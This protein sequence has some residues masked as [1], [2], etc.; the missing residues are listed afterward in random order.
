MQKDIT[1]LFND[2]LLKHHRKH[3]FMQELPSFFER[4]SNMFEDGMSKKEMFKKLTTTYS[5]VYFIFF[6][7]RRFHD[8]WQELHS[9]WIKVLE[10]ENFIR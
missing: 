4:H 5:P 10:E 9:K 1:Q 6:G 3:Q 7:C 2:F 8:G